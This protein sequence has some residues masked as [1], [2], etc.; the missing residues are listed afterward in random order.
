[1]EKLA[2]VARALNEAH[3][4]G[5]GLPPLFFFTDEVRTPDP[6]GAI[7]NL[8]RDCAVILRHYGIP[9]RAALAKQMVEACHGQGR[10]CLIAGDVR[11]GKASGAHGLHLREADLA[12]A[13]PAHG[14]RERW[15]VTASVHN[16][17]AIK[18]AED[19][20]VDALF[21]SP[22]FP[23]KSHPEAPG[24]GVARFSELAH[25]TDL[26]VY[27]LGG[28]TDETASDLLTSGAVGIA[29][30]GGLMKA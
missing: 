30:I 14:P 6:L 5:A 16:E 24:L 10:L 22:L 18:A 21:L 27:A 11:L 3:P 26:P 9:G 7:E 29:A 4:A 17:A 20:R 23:T 25:M 8:P 1:M 13:E 28:I 2:E 19:L 15:L 12:R